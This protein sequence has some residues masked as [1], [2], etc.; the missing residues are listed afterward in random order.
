MTPLRLKMALIAAGND[1]K[2]QK[3]AGNYQLAMGHDTVA[4]GYFFMVAEVVPS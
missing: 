2:L 4:A 1:R 3:I